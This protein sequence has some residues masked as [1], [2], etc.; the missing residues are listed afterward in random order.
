M[1]SKWSDSG[2][3]NK[4]DFSEFFKEE[5]GVILLRGKNSF[6]DFIYSYIKVS[7]NNIDRLQHSLRNQLPFNPSDFGEVIAAGTGEPS[8]EVKAEIAAQYPMAGGKPA[9]GAPKAQ[10]PVMPIKAAQK[11]WDEY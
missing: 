4:P 6:G 9:P 10:D 7:F 5:Y 2:T 11:A 3:S 1:T 8:D